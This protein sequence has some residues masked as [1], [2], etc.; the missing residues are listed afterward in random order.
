MVQ[1]QIASKK[2]QREKHLL[3]VQDEV[4]VVA[5][6]K[7]KLE[8]EKLRQNQLQSCVG[9]LDRQLNEKVTMNRTNVS[10]LDLTFQ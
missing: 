4:K 10:N 6:R 3:Q 5:E 7:A 8:A 2:T 1:D 9:N